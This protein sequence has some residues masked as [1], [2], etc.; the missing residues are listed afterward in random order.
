MLGKLLKYDLKWIYKVVIFFYALSILF[1]IIMRLCSRPNNS[2]LFSI[3]T[4]VSAGFTIA[5]IANSIINGIIRSWVRFRENVYKDESYLTHTL[6]VN[7][8]TIYLSKVLAAIICSFVSILVA[9]ASLCICYYSKENIE[10]LKQSLE[11]AANT[12]DTTVINILLIVSFIL[13]LEIVFII[14][15][16]YVGIILGHKANRDKVVKSILIGFG[17]YMGT[18]AFTLAM[19]GIVGTFNKD[20]RNIIETTGMIETDVIKTLLIAASFVYLVYNIFYYWIGKRQFEK[21]VNVD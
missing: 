10:F 21:G 1:A 16:G 12:Y 6:P 9:V 20:I 3:L 7:K 4:Q 5:M 14:L 17:L 11:L 8:K 18:N 19:I 2:M 13:F 15:I